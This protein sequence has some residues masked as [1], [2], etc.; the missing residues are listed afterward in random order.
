MRASSD[1]TEALPKNCS[2]D[3]SPNFLESSYDQVS[4]ALGLDAIHGLQ[5]WRPTSDLARAPLASAA[6]NAIVLLGEL[7]HSRQR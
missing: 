2:L 6:C 7:E 4:F 5:P 1:P 3:M